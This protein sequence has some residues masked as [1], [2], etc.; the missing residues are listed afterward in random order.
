MLPHRPVCVRIWDEVRKLLL[1]HYQKTRDLENLHSCLHA[2]R[3]PQPLL[4]S[5]FLCPGLQWERAG[6]RDGVNCARISDHQHP[7]AG[8]LPVLQH[9][10][11]KCEGTSLCVCRALAYYLLLDRYWLQQAPRYGQTF[12]SLSRHLQ[13]KVSSMALFADVRADGTLDDT[14]RSEWACGR[15]SVCV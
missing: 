1:L 4:Q 15:V 5:T 11:A 7:C 10:S 2:N 3:H 9:V 14:C 13:V 6:N 8:S 12:L